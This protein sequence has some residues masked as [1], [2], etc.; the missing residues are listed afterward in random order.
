MGAVVCETVKKKKKKQFYLP[1]KFGFS[2]FVQNVVAGVRAF[3]D[4]Q[5]IW[6]F[7]G[8]KLRV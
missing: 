2:I 3:A 4:V 1:V 8:Q 5:T 6:I 7:N